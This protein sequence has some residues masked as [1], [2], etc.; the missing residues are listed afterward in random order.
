MDGTGTLL[1]VGANVGLVSMLLADKVQN[2]VL[3][4]PNP[5]AAARAKENIAI[6]SF[7]F[8]VQELALSDET[9]TISFEDVGGVNTCNRTVINFSTA[10]PTRIVKRTSFDRFLAEHGPFEVPV[11]AVK[12][13]VEGHE[14]AVIRGMRHLLVTDR[15]RTV[16]FEYL[17]RTNLAEAL[18]IFASVDYR[19]MALLHNG[20]LAPVTL[21]TPPLQ[22]LFVFP[23]EHSGAEHEFKFTNESTSCAL[24]SAMSVS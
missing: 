10:A 8:E 14:V 11:S 1:D 24:Q 13:D 19:V 21:S 3:F 12:I 6:N 4:E 16:I 22:D 15:P 18:K 9:G 7:R 5:V 17:Q 2:A 20:T 23:T